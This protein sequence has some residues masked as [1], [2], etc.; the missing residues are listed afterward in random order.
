[1]SLVR[2]RSRS[3]ILAIATI[4]IAAGMV[5]ALSTPAIA[6]P[7]V[8]TTAAAPQII[9]KPVSTTLGQGQFT[10]TPHT[11]IVA[12]GAAKA[13]AQDLAGYL[14]PA[15]G[16][17]LPVVSGPALDGDITLSIGDPATLATDNSGEGYQ[18]DVTTDG[19][20]LSAKTTHGL[21]DG[22]QTIR[23]LLPAQIASPTTQTVAWAMPSVHITDYPRYGYRGVMLDIAR[24][25][26]PPAQ[27]EKLIDQAAAYKIN[28]FHLHL[29]DDQGFRLVING[30]PNLTSI[31][32]Q[33]SVGTGGKTMDPGGFWTQAQYKAVVAYAA[34]HFMTVVPEVD[35]PGHN[36]AIIMSEYNDTTNPQLDGNSQDIN[37]S[38]SNPPAWRFTGAVG[39]SALCPE[40]DNTWTILNAIIQQISAL[41]PGPYY[42][43][44]G[45]EVPTTVLSQAR[46]ASLVN[47][48]SGIVNANG[49]TTMGWA[50][51]AG[52]GTSLAPGSVAE[53]WQTASGSSSGTVTATEAVQKGMKVVMSPANHAYLDQRYTRNVPS[54]LGQTWACGQGCDVDQFYNWDPGS[55]VTG[56]TDDNVI[57]VEGALWS[58]TL[59]TL[60]DV[61]Y[62]AFPRLPA[63]AE[64]GWSPKVERTA[65]SPAYQDFLGRLA[66]QGPRLMAA[67]VNFYPSPEVP[68]HLD[69]TAAGAHLDRNGTVGGAL[70][71]LSAPGMA[72][73]AVTA[74][75]D[76]GDGSTSTGVVTGTA[77]TTTAVN[78]LYSIGANHTYARPGIY[79]AT[80]TVAGP[81]ATTATVGVTLRPGR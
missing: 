26:E 68:W 43:L 73:S 71:T 80:V 19:V 30:F 25:Y 38:L 56:V 5:A 18:L 7:A 36:N 76:W 81:N 78:G 22:V 52:T 17:P 59:V 24:H 9:P 60:D 34:A 69:L 55:Y 23:Q 42:N 16:Y 6:N 21:F 70:A 46:Y 45:D 39:Y 4:G 49:K 48:E 20:Q 47:Q 1:M 35:S 12:G 53:Y 77:A 79:Q 62:M 14:R 57:G 65:T 44:G 11:R 10:A 67:G 64:L 15:T 41:T 61:D 13:V 37:C 27:V 58:E 72:T 75:I 74:T 3:K 66:A 63:L 29:S 54:P 33:G 40:S 31:G 50:D 51:I 8:E 28:T 32:A 2:R